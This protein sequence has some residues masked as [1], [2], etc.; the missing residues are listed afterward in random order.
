[1]TAGG[2]ERF[3]RDTCCFLGSPS[4]RTEE[5]MMKRRM[6]VVLGLAFV[7]CVSGHGAVRAQNVTAHQ[8]TGQSPIN[9]GT[10]PQDQSDQHARQREM[11]AEEQA[12]LPEAQLPPPDQWGGKASLPNDPKEAGHDTDRAPY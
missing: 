6:A 10:V 9:L 11:R 2:F 8:N 1:M 7:V 5:Q 12:E 3:D 4:L